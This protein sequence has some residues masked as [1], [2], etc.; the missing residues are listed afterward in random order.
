MN[1]LDNNNFITQDSC[2]YTNNSNLDIYYNPIINYC[3]LNDNI[4]S[5]VCKDFYSSDNKIQLYYQ[6]KI[7]SSLNSDYLIWDKKWKELGC[8]SDLPI[9]I[10]NKLVILNNDIEKLIN[11]CVFCYDDQIVL[12]DDIIIYYQQ[13]QQL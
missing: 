13:L 6:Q 2:G 3:N 7:N 8:F 4:T 9:N 12:L 10:Y 5:S 11:K 1:C